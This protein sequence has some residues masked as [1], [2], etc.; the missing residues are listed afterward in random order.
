VDLEDKMFVKLNKCNES[1]IS[2]LL[3]RNWVWKILFAEFK[4]Y[5]TRCAET[6]LAA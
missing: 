5:V 2:Q 1:S 4:A 3:K 6:K